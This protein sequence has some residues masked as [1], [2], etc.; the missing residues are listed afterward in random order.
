MKTDKALRA[1]LDRNKGELPFGYEFRI[2]RQIQREVERNEKK[3]EVLGLVT[4]V[5]VSVSFF[6]GICVLLKNVFH[7]DVLQSF[8]TIRFPVWH[9]VIGTP[10]ITIFSTYSVFLYILLAILAL[11]CLDSLFRRMMHKRSTKH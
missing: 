6:A 5:S 9:P 7:I 10:E 8:A 2:M 11:L 4:V 1:A 3:R